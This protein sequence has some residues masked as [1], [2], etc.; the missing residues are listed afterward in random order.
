MEV[1]SSDPNALSVVADATIPAGHTSSNII[2]LPKEANADV[3]LTVTFEIGGP[4]GETIA[5]SQFRTGP[6]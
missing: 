2:G 4:G 5:S 6:S 3:T 1:Q